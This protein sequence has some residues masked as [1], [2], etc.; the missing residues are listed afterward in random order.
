MSKVW[1]MLASAAPLRDNKGRSTTIVISCLHKI[2]LSARAQLLLWR[3]TITVAVNRTPSVALCL[4]KFK[5]MSALL[6]S[7]FFNAELTS[8]NTLLLIQAK[9]NLQ[10]L[11]VAG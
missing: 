7:L 1:L 6:T 4:T 2:S 9:L 3:H 8:L 11:V 5:C 10:M